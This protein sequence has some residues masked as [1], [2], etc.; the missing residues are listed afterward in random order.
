MGTH[1]R[2]NS[3]VLAQDA[4]NVVTFLASSRPR[5]ITGTVLLVGAGSP[6]YLR[7]SVYVRVDWASR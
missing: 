5:Y 1:R 7:Q 3:T 2:W 6:V 4:S